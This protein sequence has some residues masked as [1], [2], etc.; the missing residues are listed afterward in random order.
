MPQAVHVSQGSGNSSGPSVRTAGRAA[1]PRIRSQRPRRSGQRDGPGGRGSAGKGDDGSVFVDLRPS[2]D[3]EYIRCSSEKELSKEF[4]NVH[5]TLSDSRGDWKQRMGALRRLAALVMGSAMMEQFVPL[6]LCLREPL[7]N[8]VQDLRSAIVREACSVIYIL[9]HA[10]GPDFEPFALSLLPSLFKITFVTIQVIAESGYQCIRAVV[11]ECRT[12]RVVGALLE[13]LGSRNATLR[14][15]CAQAILLALQTHPV[16]AIE[17]HIDAMEGAI[18]R[19]LEDAR[20][21]VRACGRR[22]F[23]AFRELFD[24]RGARLFA[25][26]DGAKQRLLESERPTVQPQAHHS[27]LEGLSPESATHDQ[28]SSVRSGS[29]QEDCSIAGSEAASSAVASSSPWGAQ[30]SPGSGLS[31]SPPPQEPLRQQSQ[32][33]HSAVQVPVA[34]PPQPHQRVASAAVAAAAARAATH[35]MPAKASHGT[36]PSSASDSQPQSPAPASSGQ[37][38]KVCGR[39]LS[40]AAAGRV[41]TAPSRSASKSAAKRAARPLGERDRVSQQQPQQQHR[42][43]QQQ[44]RNKNKPPPDIETASNG[45]ATSTMSA[46]LD[47]GSSPVSGQSVQSTVSTQPSPLSS[48]T[49]PT[50]IPMPALSMVTNRFPHRRDDRA[51]GEP[52]H[53]DPLGEDDNCAYPASL[54]YGQPPASEPRR[55]SPPAAR[56]EQARQRQQQ[57]QQPSGQQGQLRQAHEGATAGYFHPPQRRKIGPTADSVDPCVPQSNPDKSPSAALLEQPHPQQQS[58]MPSPSGSVGPP[59]PFSRGSPAASRS[60]SKSAASTTGRGGSSAH[61][62]STGAASTAS[63]TPATSGPFSSLGIGSSGATGGLSPGASGPGP[64]PMVGG[65]GGPPPPGAAAPLRASG[66][67]T[68]MFASSGPPPT[69]AAGAADLT[70]CT[71]A[72]LCR[73]ARTANAPGQRAA[74]FAALAERLRLAGADVTGGIGDTVPPADDIIDAAL[75]QLSPTEAPPVVAAALSTLRALLALR[76]T[77]CAP[78]IDR[79]LAALLSGRSQRTGNTEGARACL[80][81]LVERQLPSALV[82]SLGS[83]LAGDCGAGQQ[84]PSSEAIRLGGLDF[85]EKHVAESSRICEYLAGRSDECKQEEAPHGPPCMEWPH[86]SC[87]GCVG[88]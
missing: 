44:P 85:L 29:D 8:Q 30:A 52:T 72:R 3:I 36:P 62:A 12:H 33:Q 87:D 4:D 47:V 50:R 84:Q 86:S 63:V 69:D 70:R 38:P 80:T 34:A 31:G 61:P 59:T 58:A 79:I 60:S 43:H 57:Q 14:W 7:I 41:R 64:T 46:T 28:S 45:T 55:R 71:P 23:W 26:L 18:R 9:V 49:S 77:A 21:D 51:A 25:R 5:K 42:Q 68:G 19:C 56:A 20:D 27:S 32:Q 2:E 39:P 11:G 54:L 16:G 6:A 48:V 88:E 67:S 65:C 37:S 53:A 74:A 24:E 10:L 15:R 22:C 81:L 76:P 73:L 35:G 1:Q 13:Q 40:S 83:L 75:C 17:R 82:A 78:H 66:G